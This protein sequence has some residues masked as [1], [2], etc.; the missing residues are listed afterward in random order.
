MVL[1]TPTDQTLSNLEL[2]PK[3]PFS[4]PTIKFDGTM[5]KVLLESWYWGLRQAIRNAVST[6]EKVDAVVAHIRSGEF[7]RTNSLYK[8][9]KADVPHQRKPKNPKI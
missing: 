9:L 2:S 4:E 3:R 5:L 6:E 8:L 7:A 1:F